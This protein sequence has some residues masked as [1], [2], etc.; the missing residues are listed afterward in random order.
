[1]VHGNSRQDALQ[2]LVVLV[3]RDAKVE[4]ES[5]ERER[6]RERAPSSLLDTCTKIH[7][8]L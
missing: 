6:E 8:N 7:N 3:N 4:N 2:D 1:M 5:R